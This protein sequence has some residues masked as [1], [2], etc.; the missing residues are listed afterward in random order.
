MQVQRYIYRRTAEGVVVT[1]REELVNVRPLLR[2]RDK[3]YRLCSLAVSMIVLF[4]PHALFQHHIG[5]SAN[6]G[7]YVA[8]ARWHEG[9]WTFDDET[10]LPASDSDVFG[11][12]RT[13]TLLFYKQYQPT[14]GE[15]DDYKLAGQKSRKQ[16]V[17]EVK[18]GDDVEKIV[19]SPLETSERQRMYPFLL[20]LI[21]SQ[22]ISYSGEHD[23]TIYY[24][25]SSRSMATRRYHFRILP[26]DST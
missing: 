16:R 18:K 5:N 24:Q 20:I 3:Y 21:H 1:K 11:N 17:E 10:V 14:Q 22:D 19:A 8:I 12:S 6:S 25:A 9:W 26:L 4:S 2:I 15:V 23:R 7:H 13:A